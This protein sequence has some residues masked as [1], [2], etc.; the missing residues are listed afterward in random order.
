LRHIIGQSLVKNRRWLTGT[1]FLELLEANEEH[2]KA[3]IT[4]HSSTIMVR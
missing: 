2:P 4:K 3:T 1:G